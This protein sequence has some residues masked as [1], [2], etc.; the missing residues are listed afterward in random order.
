LYVKVV[1]LG[2]AMM[3]QAIQDIEND[4][5]RSNP[6][7]K[8]GNLYLEKMMTHEQ[9]GNA[10]KRVESG[11]IRQYLRE[12]EERDAKVEAAIVNKYIQ[13]SKENEN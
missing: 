1:Q 5:V 10:W 2:I 11:T 9:I 12:R 4:S 7:L 6:L 3:I 8:K 13:R